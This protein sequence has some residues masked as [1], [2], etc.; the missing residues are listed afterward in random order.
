MKLKSK[1]PNVKSLLRWMFAE[2]NLHKTVGDQTIT[3]EL[4]CE[5][6]NSGVNY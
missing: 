4:W 6:R 2:I 3:L 5:Q 1:H